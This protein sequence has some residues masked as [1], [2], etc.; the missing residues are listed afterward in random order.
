[1]SVC[2]GC[3]VGAQHVGVVVGWRPSDPWLILHECRKT[4][5]CPGQWTEAV[6]F[7]GPILARVAASVDAYRER[8]HPQAGGSV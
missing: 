4:P 7:P 8:N 6:M 1:M 5:A 3:G 2:P